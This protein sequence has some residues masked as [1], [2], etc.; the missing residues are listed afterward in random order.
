MSTARTC[1]ITGANKGIGLAIAR[2]LGQQ[3]FTVWLGCRD[4]AK[5]EQAAAP[6]REAGVTVHAI[7]I[8]VG[9]DAS[10]QAAV[11][12]L[13][14]Q[15]DSLDV[16][17]NNAGISLGAFP[18][19]SEESLDDIRA[20]FEVNTFGPLRV[21]QAMLPLLRQAPMARIVMMSSSLGS[22]E[23]TLDLRS[24][25]WQVGA[26]GYCASKSALNMFT[27]KLAKELADTSIKVNAADPGY[28]ATDLNGHSGP[29]SVEQAAAIA[30]RLATLDAMGP[31]GGFFHDGY[32]DSPARHPW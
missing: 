23:K 4:L 30:V 2:Q 16:L 19:A 21:T 8:D 10:V 14:A 18:P 1:F 31:T 32:A 12:T 3:G 29:R 15:Q 20:M 9:S 7:V 25:I 27:V 11:A 22:L 5:G 17:V 28:T 26:A 6:L 24:D 13:A